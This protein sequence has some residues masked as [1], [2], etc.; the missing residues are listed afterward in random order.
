MIK[1]I[2]RLNKADEI[3]DKRSDKFSENYGK[4]LSRFA[5][6]VERLERIIIEMKGKMSGTK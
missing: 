2:D 5:E 1:L 6:K 3:A 4:T